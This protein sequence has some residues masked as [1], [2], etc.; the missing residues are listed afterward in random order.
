MS[1]ADNNA[2]AEGP[3]ALWVPC[4]CGDFW[5]TLHQAHAHE[6]ACPSIDEMDFDPYSEKPDTLTDTNKEGSDA[7]V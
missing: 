5:C 6:C 4:I 1:D 2:P 3:E 7:D